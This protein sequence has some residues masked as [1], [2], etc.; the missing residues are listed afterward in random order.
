MKIIFTDLDES[1]LKENV[2][3]NEILD[4]FI[5][6]LQSKNYIIVVLTSKTSCEVKQLYKKNS[7]KFPFSAENGASFHIP[8]TKNKKDLTFNVEKNKNAASF[9]KILKILNSIP[10]RFLKNLIFSQ[11]LLNRQ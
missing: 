4:K 7:I 8:F 2:Y 1:L 3:Y 11:L 9:N 10:N 5:K 6:I